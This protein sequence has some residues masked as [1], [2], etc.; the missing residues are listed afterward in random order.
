MPLIVGSVRR[1]VS[2]QSAPTMDLIETIETTQQPV[3]INNLVLTIVIITLTLLLHLKRPR[4]NHG[5]NKSSLA[6]ALSSGRQHNIRRRKH[7]NSVFS[8]PSSLVSRLSRLQSGIGAAPFHLPVC[9][10]GLVNLPGYIAERR[11]GKN[12]T[13]CFHARIDDWFHSARGTHAELL[14]GPLP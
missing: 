10:F 13:N 8:S 2:Y 3:E 5:S 14:Q 11:D 1:S 6:V 12:D 9:K 7:R 4:I